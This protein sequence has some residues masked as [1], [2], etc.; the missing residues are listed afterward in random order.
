MNRVMNQ[1]FFKI[2]HKTVLTTGSRD[3]PTAMLASC[4]KNFSYTW[5]QVDLRLSVISRWPQQ[6]RQY[7]ACRASSTGL[8]VKRLSI[9]RLTGV[10]KLRRFTNYNDCMKRSE[11]FFFYKGFRFADSRSH[12]LTEEPCKGRARGT[13]GATCWSQRNVRFM[14]LRKTVQMRMFTVIWS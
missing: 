6:R 3:F 9:S 14:H 2:I 7:G 13:S 1:V 11:F 8:L 10:Y 4:W 5:R 12:Y